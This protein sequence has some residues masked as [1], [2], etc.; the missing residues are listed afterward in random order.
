MAKPPP[1]LFVGDDLREGIQLPLSK[2]HAHYLGTV[3]RL[4]EGSDILLFN[5]RDGEWRASIGQL[6][7]KGGEAALLNRTR[8]QTDLPAISL[9]FAPL[10]KG[11]T[12]LVVQKATELGVTTIQPVITARTNSDRFKTDRAHTI[13]TEAA[14]Q[15]E[16]LDLP[17]IRD[18]LPLA[19]ALAE[20]DGAH[21]IF[22]DEAGDDP[23]ERWGGAGGRGQAALLALQAAPPGPA[24][25]LIGPEGGFTP[26]ER[27]LVRQSE[28]ST[29]ISLGALILKAET[30][31]IT[32]VALWQAVC[33][34]ARP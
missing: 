7:R 6:G 16:R 22:C 31:A 12:D 32:A 8:T 20:R 2:E 13:A 11:P 14:E 1:R 33:G 21:L 29:A 26:E 15:S 28:N 3:L 5:G 30:A 9:W 34:H 23:E 17:D 10:K 24:I 18:P 4:V 25:I 27:A 19:K